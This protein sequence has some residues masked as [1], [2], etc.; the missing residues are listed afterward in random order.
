MCAQANKNFFMHF[1]YKIQDSSR[2][3]RLSASNIYRELA[4]K[5]GS[6]IHIPLSD[7]ITPNKWTVLQIDALHFLKQAGAFSANQPEKFVLRSMQLQ[8]SVALQGVYTSDM[9]FT[10]MTLPKNMRFKPPKASDWFAEYAWTAF[11]ESNIPAVPE[12]GAGMNA[13]LAQVKENRSATANSSSVRGTKSNLKSNRAA[14]ATKSVKFDQ[15]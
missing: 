5:N 6:S 11:P 8:S 14:S 10:A 1:D 12:G 13:D 7:A 4:F 15:D 3:C 9:A 2:V